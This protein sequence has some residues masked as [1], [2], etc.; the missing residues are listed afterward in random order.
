ME[1]PLVAVEESLLRLAVHHRQVTFPGVD[2][3]MLAGWG[4]VR[5]RC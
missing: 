5:Q 2:H 3:R 1:D 4:T